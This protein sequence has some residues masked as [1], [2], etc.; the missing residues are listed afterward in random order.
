MDK[1]KKSNP[2]A[3]VKNKNRGTTGT[4]PTLDKAQGNRSKQ[5]EDKKKR[6]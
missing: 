3:D 5:M 4:N 2:E 6:K 1:K